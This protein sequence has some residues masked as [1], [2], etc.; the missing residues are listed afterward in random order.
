M[1]ILRNRR[2]DFLNSNRKIRG[3][4][5]VVSFVVALSPLSAS[6][7]LVRGY[8]QFARPFAAASRITAIDVPPDFTATL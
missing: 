1:K 2:T 7:N 3:I 6:A 8:A 4:D 5:L